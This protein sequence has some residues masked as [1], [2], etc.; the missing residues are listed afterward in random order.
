MKIKGKIGAV[1][2]LLTYRLTTGHYLANG[3]HPF[4]RADRRQGVDFDHPIAQRDGLPRPRPKLG[5]ISRKAQVGIKANA[6]AH[7]PAKEFIERQPGGF[8]P[9]IPQRHIN[10]GERRRLDRPTAPVAMAIHTLPTPFGVQRVS[11]EDQL[12]QVFDRSLDAVR[13]GW[14]GAFAPPNQPRLVGFD[15]DISPVG[16]GTPTTNGVK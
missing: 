11:A 3:L 13:F 5:R 16:D 1:S 4:N 15:L 6:L 12:F 10:A 7:C 14:Q 8:A 9:N 2:D